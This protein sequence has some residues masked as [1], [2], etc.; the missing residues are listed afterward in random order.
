VP[1]SGAFGAAWDDAMVAHW[2]A[3]PLGTLLSEINA[4]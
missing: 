2:S 4:V 3:K 1:F